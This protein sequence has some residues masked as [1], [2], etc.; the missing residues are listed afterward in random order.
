MYLTDIIQT[1]T[2]GPCM[3]VRLMLPLAK[4]DYITLS[5]IMYLPKFY[6]FTCTVHEGVR[7]PRLHIG[8]VDF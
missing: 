2:G 1:A 8:R 3:V 6:R 5:T 7:I 4:E